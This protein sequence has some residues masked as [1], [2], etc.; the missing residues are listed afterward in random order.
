MQA[1]ALVDKALVIARDG[2]AILTS[3]SMGGRKWLFSPPNPSFA[4]ASSLPRLAYVGIN[5]NVKGAGVSVRLSGVASCSQID[6]KCLK[7][8]THRTAT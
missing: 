5:F 8:D 3:T 4:A 1:H 6:V 7:G 2:G